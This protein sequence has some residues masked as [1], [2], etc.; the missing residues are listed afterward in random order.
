MLILGP[1][2]ICLP[3]P[4]WAPCPQ[5][6]SHTHLPYIWEGPHKDPKPLPM[7]WLLAYMLAS[8]A[9]HRVALGLTLMPKFQPRRMGHGRLAYYYY[10]TTLSYSS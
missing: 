10:Y 8:I 4:K 1:L 9:L 6:K 5:G 7:L 3:L 2:I